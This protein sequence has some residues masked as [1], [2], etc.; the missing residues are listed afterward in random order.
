MQKCNGAA[1]GQLTALGRLMASACVLEGSALEIELAPT[2]FAALLGGAHAALFAPGSALAH[3]AAFDAEAARKHRSI[4]SARLGSGGSAGGAYLGS[5]DA[6]PLSDGN[7]AQLVCASVWRQ[8]LE[9]RAAE[10]GALEARLLRRRRCRRRGARA[11]GRGA[12]RG[13]PFNT[14]PYSADESRT[15]LCALRCVA[16]KDTK[17]LGR[18]S[19]V[20]APSA[21]PSAPI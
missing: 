18:G 13:N 16:C 5:D 10:L 17:P 4:L 7:K 14:G 15:E 12:R 19:C 1:V 2:L 21:T 9:S 8:L 3:L 6:T 20:L 11:G